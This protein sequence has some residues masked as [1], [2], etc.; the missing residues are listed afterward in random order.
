MHLGSPWGQYKSKLF[1]FIFSMSVNNA[2]CMDYLTISQGAHTNSKIWLTSEVGI[3]SPEVPS[4]FQILS[5]YPLPFLILIF[6]TF[7]WKY[8][9]V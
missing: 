7:L 9:T 8:D 5:G 4:E 1:L 6:F 3:N 2:F